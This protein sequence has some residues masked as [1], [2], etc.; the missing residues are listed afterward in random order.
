MRE[1]PT[2]AEEILW[3]S[4]R[5]HGS[6]HHFRRQHIIGNFI[7]DFLCLEK[8]LV[9]EVDGDIHDYQKQDDQERTEFLEQQGFRVLRFKNE[10]IMGGV[11]KVINEIKF[12]LD[13]LPLWGRVGDG[14]APKQSLF[15]IVQGGRHEDLRK[16]S[17]RTIGEMD[18]GGF[19]IGGSFVKEDMATAVKWVNEI[20]PE[21]KPR[22]L[23]GVGEPIDLIL[24]VEN[25]CDTFDCVTPTRL[26]RNGALYT[27]RGKINITN[28]KFKSQMSKIE[29]GCECY[30]CQNY[31]A[32]YISHLFRAKEMLAATLA[33]IHNLYFLN[34]LMSD[35]RESILTN[36]FPKFKEKFLRSYK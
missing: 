35:I 33:T 7:V 12:C 9:I 34:K 19:G 6:E 21:E 18:F 24:G 2:K 4:L 28:S 30:T 10:E 13:S 31:T 25:G 3:K 29:D 1:N 26:A 5:N 32:A 17:A 15:G 27:K 36:T 20:L 22:H 8:S 16:E 14:V 23:L 11:E